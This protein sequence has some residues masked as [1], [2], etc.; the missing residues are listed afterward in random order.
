ML[1]VQTPPTALTFKASSGVST[2][3]AAA[4]GFLVA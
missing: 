2:L 3:F 4:Q 1:I